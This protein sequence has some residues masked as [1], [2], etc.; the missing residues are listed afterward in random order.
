MKETLK[1]IKNCKTMF[2]LDSLSLEI[3]KNAKNGEEFFEMQREFIKKKNSL[4]RNGHTREKEGYSLVDV[5]Y[6]AIRND[7]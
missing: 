6:Q 7:S 4:K 1:K 5:T 2:E 3:V